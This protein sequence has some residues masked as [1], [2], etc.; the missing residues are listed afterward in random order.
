MEKYNEITSELDKRL[1]VGV[2]FDVQRRKIKIAEG[3]DASFY[4][5][6]GLIDEKLSSELLGFLINSGSAE[7][8]FF[9]L[10]HHDVLFTSDKEKLCEGVLSGKAVLVVSGIDVSAVIDAKSYPMRS[11]EEP[12]NDRV[13]RGPRDG[14]SESLVRNTSL[15]RRRL[16]DP[17]LRIERLTVGNPSGCDIALSYIEGKADGE[18]VSKIRKKLNSLTVSALNMSQES[19]AEAIIHRGW[20]NPFPKIRYTERPDTAAAMLEEGSVIVI[21]DNSPQVMMLPTGIFDFLQETDDFYFPPLV[22]T[23]LRFTRMI[24]FFLALI[25]TPLWYQ[26]LKNPDALPDWLKFIDINKPAAVPLLLQ[27]LLAEFMIDG[28]KLASLNTPSMLNNSLSVVGGLILGDYAVEAGW[29]SPQTILYM[30]IVAIASFTQQ[31]YELGYAVKFFRII[32]LLGVEFF[33]WWGFFGGLILTLVTIALNKTVKGS[34]SYLYPLIPFNG[35]ALLRL[36][37]RQKL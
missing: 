26:L 35:K 11:I 33:G 3:R 14:F 20:Y 21:C 24:I 4:S 23:Y 27:L 18:F 31:S 16:R 22:G 17:E 2:S 28:L 30:S 19:L 15:I 25:L 1:G 6:A 32:L 5:I 36:F 12:E 37:I 10:P 34:R 7:E 13:L 8:G 9:N 29:F